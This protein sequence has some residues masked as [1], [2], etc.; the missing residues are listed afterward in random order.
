MP[1]DINIGTEAARITP[2]GVYSI[3]YAGG[4]TP[5]DWVTT[6][7]LAYLVLQIG[8]MVPKYW[9]YITSTVSEWL[10]RWRAWRRNRKDADGEGEK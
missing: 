10:G 8:L 4:M 2:P 1:P 9:S 5:A 6:L 3:L 7:T